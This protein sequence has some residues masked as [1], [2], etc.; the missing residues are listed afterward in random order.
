MPITSPANVIISEISGFLATQSITAV[1]V[2]PRSTQKEAFVFRVL[3]WDLSAMSAI[4]STLRS[5][6]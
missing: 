1:T 5:V 4:R 2:P 3:R 6:D